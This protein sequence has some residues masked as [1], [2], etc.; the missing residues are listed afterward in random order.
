MNY[1]FTGI[2]DTTTLTITVAQLLSC[3]LTAVLS[4]LF[5]AKVYSIKTKYTQ[6]F[7]A[8][9]T[10]IPTIVT[11]IIIMVNG[12]I[13]AG[14][15]VAGTFSL[16]RFRSVP[17]TAKEIGAIFIAMGAGITIGMGYLGVAIIFTIIA[18]TFSLLL[19]SLNFGEQISSERILTISMPENLNYVSAF[20]DVFETY[21]T[22]AEL[23]SAKSTNM[24]S[25]FKLTYE[26]E[27]MNK[28][29]EKQFLDELRCRN[30]NLDIILTRPELSTN[31]L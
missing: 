15:A 20:D 27:L 3:M 29:V 4:G 2:F 8:T 19:T 13:G 6:G 5:I 11:M 14:V 12:N 1:T 21:T 26:I 28:E 16:I 9:L 30:G 18:V 22:K 7:L 23:I 17:G 10:L 25:I 31:T 24:G